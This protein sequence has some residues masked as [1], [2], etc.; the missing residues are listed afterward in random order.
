M[1][2]EPEVVAKYGGIRDYRK[3]L[4][5][6]EKSRKSYFLKSVSC[7]DVDRFAL[8]CNNTVL[9]PPLGWVEYLPTFGLG[10]D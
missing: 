5:C 6:I 7:I 10:A 2:R 9:F 8:R 1:N 4:F 3:N